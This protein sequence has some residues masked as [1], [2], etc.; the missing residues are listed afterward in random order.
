MGLSA[1]ELQPLLS[2]D[3]RTSGE[4][5]EKM[6]LPLQVHKNTA[7]RPKTFGFAKHMPKELACRHS[8]PPSYDIGNIILNGTTVK[9]GM[10]KVD[11]HMV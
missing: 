10:R 5:G 7:Q 1:N 4:C 9:E 8:A 6:E 2:R 3:L 11:E